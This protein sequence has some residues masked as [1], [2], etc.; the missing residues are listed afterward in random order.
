MS[1]NPKVAAIAVNW[2][3][4]DLTLECIGSLMDSNYDNLE[5]ILVDNGSSDGSV[6][7]IHGLFGRVRIVAN[8]SNLGFAK[9]NNQ[10]IKVAIETGSDYV[11]FLNNDATVSS[12]C[13][14]KLVNVICSKNNIGAVA[15]YIY[16]H[17][18]RDLIWYGGGVVRLWRGRIAHKHLRKRITPNSHSM[19]QTDYFSGCAALVKAS[20]LRELGGFDTIFG[21]YSEDVDLSLRIR[22][23]G[24]KLLVVP[25]ATAYHRVSV[26]AG[27]EISPFK[28]FH[29]GRSATILFRRW[30]RVYHLP[31]LIVGGFFGA[32]YISI[33][34]AMKGSINTVIAIW[35]GLIAGLT[36]GA[37]PKKFQLEY[38]NEDSNA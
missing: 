18:D 26:S 14:S 28:A 5:V 16:Y 23:N 35:R 12:D 3:Q 38:M 13:I 21:M 29:R 34:L 20:L 15:P 9:G 17:N 37:I 11:L 30:A 7:S 25:D 2:N 8:D 36:G 1:V 24:Q 32:G 22:K 27:G 33:K 4:R 10:G 19:N 31:T 6:E